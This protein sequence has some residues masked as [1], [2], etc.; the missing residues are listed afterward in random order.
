MFY[1]AEFPQFPY[2][3]WT[4]WGLVYPAVFFSAC[5]AA[6]AYGACLGSFMNV[7]IWRMPRGE[8]VV[9][10]PSHC[11]KCGAHIR[12]YDNLPVVSYLVLRG[13][14]RN[15]HA[16]YSPRYLAVEVLCGLLFVAV[17]VKC[18]LTRQVPGVMFFYCVALLFS[19]AALAPMTALDWAAA[20]LPRAWHCSE[21]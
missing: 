9:N 5:F 3:W 21:Q 7:C 13:R 10:A 15:C 12:W 4:R 20:C 16:P 8:S 17:L 2:D 1:F 14:C 6:F 18:G 11:T 19:V